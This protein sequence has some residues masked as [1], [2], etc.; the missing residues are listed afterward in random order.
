M[1]DLFADVPNLLADLITY[2]RPKVD[3][4][5]IR[6]EEAEGTDILLRGDRIETLSEGI[7][8]GGTCGRAIKVVGGLLALIVLIA[9]KTMCSR[10]SRLLSV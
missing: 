1:S 9:L 3:Y 5:A 8:V 2:Y 10:R 7:A 6:L 4:L